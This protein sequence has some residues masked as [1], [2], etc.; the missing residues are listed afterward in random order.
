MEENKIELHN[1]EVRDIISRPPS[2]LVRYGITVIAAVVL[3][4]IIGSFIFRYPDVVVGSVTITGA[5][6]PN[7]IVAR[8][9]GRLQE[10]R[11]ADGQ[12]V[13][14]GDIIAVIENT[15]CTDDVIR[16]R[17]AVGALTIQG[18]PIPF[19]ADQSLRLGIIQDAYNQF[20][21]AVVSYNQAVN[22]NYYRQQITSA[23]KEHASLTKYAGNLQRQLQ[24]SQQ[25]AGLAKSEMDRELTLHE[26][27]LTSDTE[28]EKS[29]RELLSAQLSVE[30]IRTDISQTQLS[31][32]QTENR[33]AELEVQYQQDMQHATTT[34]QAALNTL[35]V[36]IGQWEYLYAL[37]VPASGMLSYTNV[38]AINQNITT[39]D[40]IF[41]VVDAKE[42]SFVGKVLL[43]SAGVGKVK[44]GQR[45]NIMLDS[46]PY[47]E[48]GYLRGTVSALS[49]V[50][51]RDVYV[52]TI[53]LPQ[54]VHTT[55]GRD[56]N[57]NGELSGQAEIITDDISLAVRIIQPLRYL[58]QHNV[59]N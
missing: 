52:A 44:Q 9:D 57:F 1:E 21:D 31:I 51:N 55:A 36:A 28:K 12:R 19:A 30:Q 41:S 59:S 22:L 17:K 53:S 25:Q 54:G 50:S 10:L 56:L 34:L 43:P 37:V 20:C 45:V 38:W 6:P 3:V 35:K 13:A 11:I 8:S 39:G 16:V 24:L 7:R 27:K 49:S 2:A 14:K 32:A 42:S 23:R 58:F 29:Q 26:R 33:L 40:H 15:A 5:T 4:V 48:F 18:D 47:L 46:Y